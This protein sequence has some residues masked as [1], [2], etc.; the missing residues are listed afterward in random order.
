[1]ATFL[2]DTAMGKAVVSQ[3]R[4]HRM[5][6]NVE[7][8]GYRRV[9]HRTL[10]SGNVEATK[11]VH[12]AVT[13][14]FAADVGTLV[15]KSLIYSFAWLR[16]LRMLKTKCSWQQWNHIEDGEHLKFTAGKG[17]LCFR[18]ISMEGLR[19]SLKINNE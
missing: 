10:R 8:K 11:L 1:M 6:N 19:K 15:R 13:S 14:L 5:S 16:R 12:Y 18:S 4:H 7:H 9:L 3:A 17:L 2:E